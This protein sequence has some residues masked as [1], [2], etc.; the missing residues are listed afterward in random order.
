M[1]DNKEEFP[2]V[3]VIIPCYN[4]ERGIVDT[5]ESL[6]KQDYP[7]GR[8]ETI[9]V[10]NN[11]TDNSVG[12]VHSFRGLIPSLKIEREGRQSSYAARNKGISV[13]RG[14]ILAFVDAN[15]TIWNGWIR[16]GIASIMKGYDYVGCRVDVYT[17]Q[18]AANL[19]EIHDM[20]TSFP[21]RVSW[22]QWGFAVTAGL[23]VRRK[24]FDHVGLFDSRLVS[25]GDLEF[26]NRV[27]DAGIKQY[28]DHDNPVSHPARS[29]LRSC[30]CRAFRIGRGHSDLGFFYRKRSFSCPIRFDN[31]RYV[32]RSFF[33]SFGIWRYVDVSDLNGRHKLGIWF[34]AYLLQLAHVSG[35]LFSRIQRRVTS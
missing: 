3:S 7:E 33:P 17:A 21:S 26:G 27:K 19:W 6:A 8:W 14:E 24:V 25:G 12:V 34:V 13:S 2:F 4:D 22:D 28:Y 32:V 5:L 1:K 11:S 10:D 18:Q 31:L 15:V 20:L 30:C 16:R 23:F 35:I 29:D 9:V